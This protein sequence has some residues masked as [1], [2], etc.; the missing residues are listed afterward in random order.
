MSKANSVTTLTMENVE[1]LAMAVGELGCP[2]GSCNWYDSQ[3]VLNPN[4]NDY[5]W[6]EVLVCSSCCAEGQSAN[7]SMTGCECY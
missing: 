7:C 5:E 4:T 6:T 2:G 3:W 1:A